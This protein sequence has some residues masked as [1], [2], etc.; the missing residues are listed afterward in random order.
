MNNKRRY[1]KSIRELRYRIYCW[2]SIAKVVALVTVIFCGIGCTAQVSD[3][4]RSKARDF[5]I[6]RSSRH[7]DTTR[8]REK[9]SFGEIFYDSVSDIRVYAFGLHD[10]PH[11][12]DYLAVCNKSCTESII[13]DY[14]DYYE[15]MNNT[16]KAIQDKRNAASDDEV[17]KLYNALTT[18]YRRSYNYVFRC[19]YR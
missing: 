9:I 3:N 7:G 14:R 5:L 19:E 2:Y 8:L 18:F 12:K 4:I 11:S 13:I 15:L 6:K 1:F 16:F 10:G 17:M